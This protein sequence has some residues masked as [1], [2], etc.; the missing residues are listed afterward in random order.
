MV[1]KTKIKVGFGFFL[2]VGFLVIIWMVGPWGVK[3]GLAQQAI[4]GHIS[5]RVEIVEGVPATEGE[6]T[7]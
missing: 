4:Y 3:E 5:G 1:T 6:V 7:I 2:I